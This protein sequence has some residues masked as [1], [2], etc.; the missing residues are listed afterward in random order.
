MPY[1]ECTQFFF[2]NLNLFHSLKC[3]LLFSNYVINVL[4]SLNIQ[5]TTNCKTSTLGEKKSFTNVNVI[6]QI[7]VIDLIN[8]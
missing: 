4:S 5:C 1:T 3:G 8:Y 2:Q 6:D 7:N